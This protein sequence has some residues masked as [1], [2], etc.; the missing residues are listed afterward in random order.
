MTLVL[1]GGGGHAKV[2]MDA[3]QARNHLP[4]AYVD[5]KGSPWLDALRI[6]QWSE[7]KLMSMLGIG[8]QCVAAFVGLDCAALERR[9][10]LMQKYKS[11]GAI[12]PAVIHPSAIISKTAKIADGVQILA[13][14]IVNGDATIGEGAVVNTGAVIE[15][16]AVVGAGAHIAP[17]AVV[18][19]GAQ[20]GDLA[21][22]GS[23]AVIIQNSTVA[24]NNFIKALSVHRL[25][26]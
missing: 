8:V 3:L 11:S 4:A 26:S 7:E 23:N 24:A 18:L 12:L 13:G 1:L 17:R 16:D 14:A 5:S 2:V 22:V 15:H 9:L 20:V 10:Q 6:T 21:Y 25:N 19:G